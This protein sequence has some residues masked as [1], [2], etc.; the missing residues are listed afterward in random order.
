MY[1]SLVFLVEELSFSSRNLVLFYFIDNSNL[2]LLNQ[3]CNCA[4]IYVIFFFWGGGAERRL[5]KTSI[6]I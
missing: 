6:I 3:I 2:V 5:F 1:L 4:R